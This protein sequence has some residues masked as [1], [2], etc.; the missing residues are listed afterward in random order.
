MA[1]VIKFFKL[2]VAFNSQ[3]NVD[4]LKHFRSLNSIYITA[5]T[6]KPSAQTFV[7]YIVSRR[8]LSNLTYQPM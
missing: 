5:I 4:L 6:K 8:M 7:K 2:S 1:L 3:L